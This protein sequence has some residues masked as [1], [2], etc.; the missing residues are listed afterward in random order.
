MAEYVQRY[1]CGECGAPAYY[2][3]RCGDG[4]VLTC[5][6]DQEGVEYYDGRCGDGPYIV[7]HAKPVPASSGRVVR[8]RRPPPRNGR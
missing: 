1:V 6:C 3:G 8:R 7:S 4:P 5:G 2:D